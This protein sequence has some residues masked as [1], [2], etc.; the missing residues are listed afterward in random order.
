MA[1]D[2]P[3][4]QSYKTESAHGDLGGYWNFQWKYPAPGPGCEN[5]PAELD[6]S[7]PKKQLTQFKVSDDSQHQLFIWG[8]GH[9]T[10]SISISN[11][12]CPPFKLLTD[13]MLAPN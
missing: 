10:H 5:I 6:N 13:A 9:G 2:T 3:P 7:P 12:S 8:H 11:C 4:P 1:H